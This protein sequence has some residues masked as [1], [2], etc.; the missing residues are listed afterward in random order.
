MEW[1]SLEN[2][3]SMGGRGFYVWGSYAVMALL[4]AAEVFLLLRRHRDLRRR[5]AE[6]GEGSS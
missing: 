6:D 4:L 3:L 2:F 5:P 1:G